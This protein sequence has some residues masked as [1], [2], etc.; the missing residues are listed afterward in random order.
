LLTLNYAI[1]DY[2]AKK[3]AYQDKKEDHI[4]QLTNK[5]KKAKIEA[6][7]RFKIADDLAY[8]MN[9]NP[10]QPIGHHSHNMHVN[11]I[12]K[13][14]NNMTKGLEAQDK[15][16]DYAYQLQSAKNNHVISSSD[17][18]AIKKLQEKLALLENKQTFMVKANKDFKNIKKGNKSILTK[19][20]QEIII[21]EIKYYNSGDNQPYPV[22]AL[23]NNSANIRTIK[24]RIEKLSKFAKQESTDKY[25]H[26]GLPDFIKF[27]KDT[28]ENRFKVYIP[29]DIYLSKPQLKLLFQKF[30]FHFSGRNEC[31]QRILSGIGSLE[32]Y[33]IE[34]LKKIFDKEIES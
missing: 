9:G 4:D 19:E 24:Q 6:D 34:E 28:I 18:D 31:F 7:K 12:N 8:M 13:M 25:T 5:V 3:E 15:A 17:P 14:H 10:I 21:K 33:L 29:Q 16:A 2:D 26:E 32:D 20:E 30:A 23:Q 1:K 22:Y 27:E 11:A